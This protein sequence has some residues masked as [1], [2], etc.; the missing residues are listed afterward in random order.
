MGQIMKEAVDM[1][2]VVGCLCVHPCAGRNILRYHY[3]LAPYSA[4]DTTEELIAPGLLY[5][6]MTAFHVAATTIGNVFNVVYACIL[7]ELDAEVKARTLYSAGSSCRYLHYHTPSQQSIITVAP[8]MG[9]VP[10]Y[11]TIS[12]NYIEVAM[13]V[14]G[15]NF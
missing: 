15:D 13:P 3:R 10:S 5:F 9:P 1:P 2:Y 6:G 11:H 7:T 14:E 8:H 12:P 4:T